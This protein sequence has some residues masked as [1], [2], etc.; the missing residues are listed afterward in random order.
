MIPAYAITEGIMITQTVNPASKSAI[1]H[2][3][4]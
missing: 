3:R 1:S 4:R 2:S